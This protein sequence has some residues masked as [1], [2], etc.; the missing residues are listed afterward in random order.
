LRGYPCFCLQQ[1]RNQEAEKVGDN[2]VT[3]EKVAE[4][5]DY[6]YTLPNPYKNWQTGNQKNAVTV[7]KFIKAWETK[8]LDECLSYFG[9]TV[10]LSLDYFHKVLPHDSLANLLKGSWEDYASM[11]ITMQD[12]ESVISE[13]KKDEWVTL[14]Y[15]QKWVDKKGKADSTNMVN[16]AKIVNGKIV[17]FDEKVQHYPPAAKK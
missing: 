16:D 9:D 14:W 4:K 12:W 15:K 6:P 10:D 5:L 13:D 11:T 2:S 3:I 8:N 1:Q 17:V 7:L